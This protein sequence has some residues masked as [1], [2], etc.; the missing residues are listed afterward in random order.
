MDPLVVPAAALGAPL[1][2]ALLLGHWKRRRTPLVGILVLV[3]AVLGVYLGALDLG[4]RLDGGPWESLWLLLV[5][6]EFTLLIQWAGGLP[7]R[8]PLG[9]LAFFGG[10][11][12]G[13][14]GAA[15]LICPR[16]GAASN[17][18]RV[19]L[20]ASAGA[21]LSPMGS[22]VTLLLVEAGHFGVLLPLLLAAVAW[23]RGWAQDDPSAPLLPLTTT[24]ANRNGVVVGAVLLAVVWGPSPIWALFGGC[25][26]LMFSNIRHRGRP[27]ASWSLQLWVCAM[28]VLAF[29]SLSS[30]ALWEV[31]EGLRLLLE[32]GGDGVQEGAVLVGA[33]LSAVGTEIGAAVLG[34]TVGEAGLREISPEVWS[35]L[36]AGLAVGGLTPLV[37]SQALRV[38]IGLWFVQ[39]GVV[40]LWFAVLC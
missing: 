9:P 37:L 4:A 11:L 2:V 12:V 35:P 23:P 28:A 20:T 18:A 40:L 36:C 7:L 21:L 26:V 27:P 30:G 29:F 32:S 15:L 39:L 31:K 13:E 22:P 10:A 33:A 8:G 1:V 16:A 14:V 5:W 38:G 19:A 6:L 34:V 25:L 3:G 24:G 17:R